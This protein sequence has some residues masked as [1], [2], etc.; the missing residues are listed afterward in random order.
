MKI[1]ALFIA[2]YLVF[3]GHVLEQKINRFKEK[4]KNMMELKPVENI[5]VFLERPW[6][7]YTYK[8]SLFY[9]PIFLQFF[10]I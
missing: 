8:M 10:A 4:P 2:I 9:L 7:Q 5:K 3:K 1:P 6:L